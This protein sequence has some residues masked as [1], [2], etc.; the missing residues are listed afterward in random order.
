MNIAKRIVIKTPKELIL[1]SIRIEKGGFYIHRDFQE[2]D[3]LEE[4][5]R[6]RTLNGG[7]TDCISTLEFAGEYYRVVLQEPH[8]GVWQ[9]IYTL[10]EHWP[11]E[12]EE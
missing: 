1:S 7:I 3:M 8:D 4:Y 9:D 2:H 12:P 11:E 10:W 5:D 6:R